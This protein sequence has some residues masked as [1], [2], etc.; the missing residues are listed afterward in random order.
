M[1]N[2]NETMLALYEN[3]SVFVF[4]VSECVSLSLVYRCAY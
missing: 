4:V 2:K 1:G 3:I